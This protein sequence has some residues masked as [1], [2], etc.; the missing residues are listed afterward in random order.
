MNRIQPFWICNFENSEGEVVSRI[1]SAKTST[2]ADTMA[3]QTGLRL[4]LKPIYDSI[5]RATDKEVR[6]FKKM[7][8]DRVKQNATQA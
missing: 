7:I 2:Q 4:N 8:K 5:R 3:F 1:I 6:D